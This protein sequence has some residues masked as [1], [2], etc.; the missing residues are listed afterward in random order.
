ML[1]RI[2]A[3]FWLK[4]SFFVARYTVNECFFIFLQGSE[5][6]RQNRCTRINKET[7]S[8]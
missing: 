3:V 1:K 2:I 8:E 6:V 7:E 5:Q 4:E